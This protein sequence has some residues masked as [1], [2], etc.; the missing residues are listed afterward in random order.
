MKISEYKK[1]KRFPLH[2]TK[3][4]TEPNL[5]NDCEGFFVD[6]KHIKGRKKGEG[7]YWGYVPGSGGDIWWIEH[8]NN[9]IAA[10]LTSEVF[11]I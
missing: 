11:D 6:N 4:R 5:E 8:E 3:V 10:Y 9:L 2:G 7:K 1:N